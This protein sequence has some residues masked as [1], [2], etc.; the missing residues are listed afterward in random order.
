[1][2]NGPY[3]SRGPVETSLAESFDSLRNIAEADGGEQSYHGGSNY[4]V[5]SLPYSGIARKAYIEVD[6]LPWGERY[7]LLLER[8]SWGLLRHMVF[9]FSDLATMAADQMELSI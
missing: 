4:L 5:L 3:R 7:G 8:E 9:R 6:H 2:Q 1:M